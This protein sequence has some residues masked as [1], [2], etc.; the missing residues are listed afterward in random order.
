MSNKLKWSLILIVIVLAL[1]YVFLEMNRNA[2]SYMFPRRLIRLFAIILVAFVVATSTA[3]FQALTN[4]H[5]LTPSMLGYDSIYLLMQTVL[6]FVL[7]STHPLSSSSSLLFFV[8][9]IIMV[10]L[11]T[12]LFVPL[13]RYLR[14]DLFTFLLIGIV[15]ATLFRSVTSFL[16]MIIDPNEFSIIQDRSFA[17]FNNMN[18]SL[19]YIAYA[20]VIVT[21][22]VFQHRIKELD[23]IALG[24]SQ[25]INLGIDYNKAT[26]EMIVMI[27]ILISVS[28]ALVGPIMFLG[29]LVVNIARSILATYKHSALILISFLIG[30]GI[31]LIGQTLLERYF[32]NMIPLGV[33][34]NAFGGLYLLYLLVKEFKRI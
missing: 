10:G 5:I 31:I 11:S 22:I 33:V 8:T 21:T 1:L 9:L 3:S 30:A 16:Q 15:L 4:H 2:F 27:G 6:I 18:V 14:H 20:I 19:I 24:K 34:I 13:L 12:I 23:C 25:A 17:S 29:L 7:G 26:T 28:T 32:N